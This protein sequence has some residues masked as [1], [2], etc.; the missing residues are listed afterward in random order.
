M[1][2]LKPLKLVLAGVDRISAPVTRISRTIDRMQKPIRAVTARL[3]TLDRASGFRKLRG[4]AV[5]VGRELANLGRRAALLGAVFV[6]AGARAV[7]SFV[8]ATDAIAKTADVAGLGVEA[9]QAYRF[10][11]DRAGVSQEKTD[12]GL[13]KFGKTIGELRAGTGTLIT[14]LKKSNPEFLK[15]LA[16]AENTTDAFDLFIRKLAATE[17]QMD[18]AALANAGL[19][20]TGQLMANAVKDGIEPFEKLILLASEL[21]FVL[22]EE[23]VRKGEIAKDVF[24]DITA[25][26]KGL[27]LQIAGAALPAILEASEGF[28]TWARAN[29]EL[30]KTRGTE[31]IL[32]LI[33]GIK[34]FSRSVTEML[35][36]VTRV[37]SVL[38]DMVGIV[39]LLAIVI[40]RKLIF[41]VVSFGIALASTP[42]GLFLI[43]LGLLAGAAA[44][45]FKNW[46]PIK[47][48]FAGLWTGIID[49]LLSLLNRL[50]DFIRTRIGLDTG[51]A[52]AGGAGAVRGARAPGSAALLS[53][54][55][56]STF[57][58]RLDVSISQDRPPRVDRLESS[59]PDLDLAVDTGLTL[60]PA[61]GF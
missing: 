4:A 11:F 15:Q 44:L 61:S 48:F 59:N 57:S 20:R 53:S 22:D 54:G 21:G 27:A 29:R 60:L 46:E 2:R 18:R 30:I 5:G 19:G 51:A 10:A 49:G 31:F 12:K 7:L 1:P 9:L 39:R 41:A 25:V 23:T 3:R 52:P 33:E 42:L 8:D 36:L 24:T 40:L 14:L 17:N 55:G 56:A 16:N 26:V 37:V 28:L 58:G 32:A 43:A 38:E 45:I 13:I 47:K 34:S 50:P 6:A 35:P